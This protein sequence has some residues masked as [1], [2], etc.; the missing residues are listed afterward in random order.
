[1]KTT[2]DA[3]K[4]IILRNI[5][6]K[7][8]TE[9]TRKIILLNGTSLIG[10]FFLSAFTVI[11]YIQGAYILS[12]MDFI[13]S[14]LIIV[15][16][17]FSYKGGSYTISSYVGTSFMYILYLYLF[18]SG[19]VNGTAFMWQYTYPLFSLFL[20]GVKAGVIAT[21]CLFIPSL[22]F[23]IF[24]L[25][26]QQI[27]VYNLDFAIR[28]IPSF[29][30]VFLFSYIYE[31]SRE[32]AQ[33]M[34]KKANEDQERIIEERTVQL[35]KEIE[36][37]EE[38][39]KQLRQSQKMKAI[40]L[41]AGGVAHDL[42][43]ILSG[44]ASYPELILQKLPA[45]SEYR[46]PLEAIWNSGKRSAAVVADLLTVARGVASTKV[47]CNVNEIIND[48]MISPEFR[49]MK[50]HYPGV[51]FVKRFEKN[52]SHIKCSSVHI[53]K[54]I[55]NIIVNA[56]E[57]IHDTGTVT[58]RTQHK[59]IDSALALKHNLDGGSYVIVSIEDTGEGIS[60]TDID[61]IF[62]PFYS[63][64]I[65]GRS[66][67]GLGLA[68]AWN[69]VQDH[70]GAILVTSSHNGSVFDLYF[71]SVADKYTKSP[72]NMSV[73]NFMGHGEKVLIVDDEELQLDITSQIVT[74][75]GYT[76]TCVSSGEEAINYLKNNTVELVILDM[77]MDPGINGRETFE[78]IIKTYP[79]QAAI[80]ASGF[81]KSEDV[82]KAIRLGVK[83]FIHKP[84]SIV[85]LGK[86]IHE[87]LV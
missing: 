49:T 47:P 33:K 40:G 66:G 32:N 10:L 19:G 1:M 2:I 60:D 45:D 50:S 83:G 6:D 79:E 54:S 65:I 36:T 64:K 16:L 61:H 28:Y 72:E 31:K 86:I 13:S 55:M 46:K 22:S 59:I 21:T 44:I 81:S 48:Y 3:L 38:Y 5:A 17:F 39:S 25:Y 74:V 27:N 85:E 69:S 34:L 56:S 35:K 18:I 71:P 43:N 29:L 76:P 68:V 58:I 14:I 57:A 73:E 20:L 42:N 77:L 78:E 23:L 52:L 82:M 41:M 63:K 4:S 80:I 12:L 24:D 26:S 11:A 37:R 53:R 84:Y 75:L 15:M 51:K 8:D 67:T 62:E 30:C 87:S 70:N 9:L 7:N